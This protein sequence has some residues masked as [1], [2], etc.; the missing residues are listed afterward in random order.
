MSASSPET[1][2]EDV[3]ERANRAVE[4]F[5]FDAAVQALSAALETEYGCI[6]TLPEADVGG[7]LDRPVIHVIARCG[8]PEFEAMIGALMDVDLN[9]MI[10]AAFVRDD[11]EMTYAGSV[12]GDTVVWEPIFDWSDRVGDFLLGSVALS[13]EVNDGLS[14]NAQPMADA[15][16]DCL[17]DAGTQARKEYAKCQEEDWTTSWNKKL[18][19][20]GCPVRTSAD[21]VSGCSAVCQT[22]SP[23]VPDAC[24]A[25]EECTRRNLHVSDQL[26]IPT[27]TCLPK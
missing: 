6:V 15:C 7:Q 26:Y 19:G 4:K 20:C 24:P 13:V 17:S 3:L 11:L 16:G 14:R 22:C 25:G 1:V 18:S 12:D 10:A 8:D 5:E 21:I 27:E 23:G 9:I 2:E